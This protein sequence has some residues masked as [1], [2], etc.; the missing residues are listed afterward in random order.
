MIS[1]GAGRYMI[2]LIPGLFASAVIQPITKFLQSQSLVYPLLLSSIATMVIHIL[3]CYVMV[4]KTGFGYTGA[5][6]AVS[7]SFWLNVAMLVGYVM[8]SSSC[9]ET[10]TPLT[11]DTFKGVDTFLR[12][13]LPTA[14]M[15]C[16]ELWSFEL[17]ILV[18]GL[19]P[20]P[21][22]ETSVLSICL[23]SVTLIST[24]P[25]GV[26]AAASTRVAN[27][28]G[29][30]NPSG[31]RSVVRIAMSI[32]MTG[33]VIMSGT[34]LVA[35]HLLGR[36]YS[37][38]EEVISFVASMVPLVCI[39]VVTDAVQGVLAGVAR[40]CG[41]Q[42]LAAY[43]NF[44]SFYLLGI[45][46]AIVLSFV[47][48]LGAR[49]LWMGVVCGSL[50]QTTLMGAITFFINWPKMVCA[51]FSRMTPCNKLQLKQQ[52]YQGYLNHFMFF[53]VFSPF[54][55]SRCI[56]LVYCCCRLRRPGK[57]RLVR[58]WRSPDH[59]WSR[60][61]DPIFQVVVRHLLMPQHDLCHRVAGVVRL[62]ADGDGRS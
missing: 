1:N 28:L 16:L 55:F 24:V 3:L 41:W 7:I 10:R 17:L 34:L 27:E 18:S 48:R 32:T 60:C 51:V 8:F 20:N 13:A 45:P 38:E 37:D 46:V 53:C 30:G 58:S 25:F 36:A 52:N 4:F 15:I 29:S 12:L 59:Y 61:T 6:L 33:A 31:A 9:K 19:L 21:E 49:G 44:G 42:H 35:R 50:T 56:A 22:L 26:G 54:F 2:S 43:V 62:R 23:T 47:L 14:L 5:A 57:G 11:I 40:G 39:T